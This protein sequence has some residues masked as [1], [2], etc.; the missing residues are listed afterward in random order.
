M[1]SVMATIMLFSY[2]AIMLNYVTTC[3]WTVVCVSQPFR[4]TYWIEDRNDI[5][6][7]IAVWIVAALSA[8]VQ[9]PI[10]ISHVTSDGGNSS[11][12]CQYP[13][14]AI[15]IE[16]VYANYFVVSLL[17]QLISTACL[18]HVIRVAR[19]HMTKINALDVT[20]ADPSVRI[21]Q[22]QSNNGL[23]GGDVV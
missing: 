15:P 6:S 1:C 8:L 18:C 14:T 17:T 4:A 10:T 21:R 7:F 20:L 5:K 12:I 9:L 23:D 2:H 3:I 19:R 13:E 22:S 16:Q 11:A